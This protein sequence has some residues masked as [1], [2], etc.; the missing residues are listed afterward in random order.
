[1]ANIENLMVLAEVA[2]EA[3]SYG[4][5]YKYSSQVLEGDVSNSKA[6]IL[7][8]VAAAH[9]TDTSG[10]QIEEAKALI[11]RGL[12]LGVDDNVKKTASIK[13]KKAYTSFLSTLD[14]ELFEKVKDYQ[15]V[16]MPQN[17][18]VILH[19]VAQQAN[20]IV[21]AKAQALARA[22]ALQM[23]VIMCLLDPSRDN[24]SYAINALQ[25]AKKHSVDNA[26]YLD[27]NE[28]LTEFSEVSQAINSEAQSKFADIEI[29]NNKAPQKDGC[30]IATAAAGSYDHPKVLC[31]RSFRDDVLM[32]SKSG[33]SFVSAYYKISPP[34]ASIVSKSARLRRMVMMFIVN[35]AVLLVYKIT[36]NKV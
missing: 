31:L 7:K 11:A 2:S 10:A 25:A 35:P 19:N 17:G 33:R 18:S 32:Q 13:I 20:R 1:M 12:G 34:I 23:M 9:L 16:A 3:N 15:K 36:R 26:N 8:G 28:A 21:S 14:S 27:S 22:K 6:W 24:Y 4:D 29:Y 30:F 5:V